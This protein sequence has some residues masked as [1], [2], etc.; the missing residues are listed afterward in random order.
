MTLTALRGPVMLKTS[1]KFWDNILGQ[2]VLLDRYPERAIM[3]TAMTISRLRQLKQ[4]P[5]PQHTVGFELDVPTR[6]SGGTFG[7]LSS[8]LAYSYA[9]KTT[10]PRCVMAAHCSTASLDNG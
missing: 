7:T 1:L 3:S 9:C 8:S 2:V 4:Q 5:Q 10:A 6:F